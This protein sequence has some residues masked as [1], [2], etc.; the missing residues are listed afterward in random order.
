MT[1]RVSNFATL[2]SSGIITWTALLF[3]GTFVFPFEALPAQEIPQ[4]NIHASVEK[5]AA[6]VNENYFDIK[7]ASRI[8]KDLQSLSQP[9][10]A[11]RF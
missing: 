5:I 3:I 9:A 11:W 1:H 7:L 8:Q 4:A 2:P 6:A 10:R